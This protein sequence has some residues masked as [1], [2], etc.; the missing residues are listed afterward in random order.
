MNTQLLSDATAEWNSGEFGDELAWVCEPDEVVVT[1]E[2][3]ADFVEARGNPSETVNTA[4]GDLHIW[5]KQQSR[6]GCRRG[7]LFLLDAGTSR[8]SYFGGET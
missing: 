5:Q 4:A 7:D 3:L 6:P 8:L 2:T 1:A